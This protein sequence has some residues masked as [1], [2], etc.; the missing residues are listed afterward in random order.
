MKR[1]FILLAAMTLASCEKVIDIE[2]KD[3]DAKL[4]I[5]AELSNQNEPFEVKVSKTTNFSSTN[6]FNGVSGA[7]VILSDDKGRTQTL[8]ETTKGIYRTNSLVGV[9]NT[10]YTLKV[11][12]QGASYSANS[13]MPRNVLL[14]DLTLI[15][16]DGPGPAAG[17]YAATPI[18]TDPAEL[19][20]QYRFIQYR[21]GERDAEY[22]ISNDNIRNGQTNVRPLLSRNFE[23]NLGDQYTLEMRCIDKPTYEYFFSLS[24]IAGNGPGGGT[25]PS[26]PINNWSN[27]ALGYFSAHTVQKITKEVK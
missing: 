7:V 20:N 9:E 12:Y 4:V 23:V 5:E 3:A 13:T 25:T 14:K 10:R 2:L 1:I 21:N 19:G 27:G 11:D 17:R 16:Q 6:D 18:Y 8:A 26:N 22:L 24:Q 15:K